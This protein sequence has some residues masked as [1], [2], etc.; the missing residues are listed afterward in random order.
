MTTTEAT[1]GHDNYR[2]DCWFMTAT[3]ATAGSWQ[4]QSRINKQQVSSND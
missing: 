3:E 1:A 4:L 2:G